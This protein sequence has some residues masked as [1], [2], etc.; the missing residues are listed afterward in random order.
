MWRCEITRHVHTYAYTYIYIYI[1]AN[2]DIKTETP[3]EGGTHTHWLETRMQKHHW[4][5]RKKWTSTESM[6]IN[7]IS[8]KTL[9]AALT[10]FLSGTDL[11]RHRSGLGRQSRTAHCIGKWI[12]CT[13]CSIT[14]SK[15]ALRLI[16]KLINTFQ[17]NAKAG[18][19][20]MKAGVLWKLHSAMEPR[21]TLSV[22][23]WGHKASGD[24]MPIK[25]GR[26]WVVWK[27]HG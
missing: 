18:R 6:W 15:S 19:L 27:F 20:Q 16:A 8:E 17:A 24:L 26:G 14:I 25:G 10:F 22:G 12:K 11:A 13:K 2:Q 7:A 1:Y 21:A 4:H 23:S 5:V 9:S 3:E